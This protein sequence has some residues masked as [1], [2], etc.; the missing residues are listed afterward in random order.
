MLR[1]PICDDDGAGH[2]CAAPAARPLAGASHAV[3]AAV[4]VAQCEER[5][6]PRST[7]FT[8]GFCAPCR[9]AVEGAGQNFL[10]LSHKVTARLHEV[11]I[12]YLVALCDASPPYHSELFLYG[13]NCLTVLQHAMQVLLVHHAEQAARALHWHACTQPQHMGMPAGAA[14]QHAPAHRPAAKG[15]APRRTRA[16][17]ATF[18][19]RAC[20]Q[21]WRGRPVIWCQLLGRLLRGLA[22]TLRCVRVPARDE[23]SSSSGSDFMARALVGTPI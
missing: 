8:P 16:Q 4:G 19:W 6:L 3:S 12:K 18:C 2:Y 21:D 10:A 9:R 1:K 22:Q 13:G 14:R 17:P 11:I 7:P 5:G 15:D 23:F 20:Q